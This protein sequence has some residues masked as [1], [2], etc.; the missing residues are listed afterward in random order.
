MENSGIGS[1]CNTVFV[2]LT[3]I[4]VAVGEDRGGEESG[5]LRKILYKS[6]SKLEI[7]ALTSNKQFSVLSGNNFIFGTWNETVAH[8]VPH[9]LW[10][11]SSAAFYIDPVHIYLP[12]AC[13][14]VLIWAIK[15]S[16]NFGN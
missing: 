6:Q 12:G 1:C 13:E 3:T 5:M 7:S 10:K 9:Y 8:V 4:Q 14:Q 11:W 15:V 2:I 16:I